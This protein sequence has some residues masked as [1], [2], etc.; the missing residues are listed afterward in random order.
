[1]QANARLVNQGELEKRKEKERKRE[2]KELRKLAKAQG[3]KIAKPVAVASAP[4]LAPE[5]DTG[6]TNETKP[7]GFKKA[8]WAAVTTVPKPPDTDSR[9]SGWA[10]ASPALPPSD[11]PTLVAP[12]ASRSL[13]ASGAPV[14][15]AGGWTSLDPTSSRSVVPPPSPPEP[16]VLP[17]PPP[18]DVPLPTPPSNRYE[19][20][21]TSLPPSITLPPAS[22]SWATIPDS[23]PSPPPTS[24]R[25]PLPPPPVA[26]T[27]SGWQQWKQGNNS[28]RR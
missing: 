4:V 19:S 21:G 20:P 9:R 25:A 6:S 7:G 13:P 23:H 10:T 15:R 8:G 3:I 14:F 5:N 2:E 24:L 11:E 1:M 22:Q 26:P 27:R 17:P 12:S 18:A 16:L 28:K